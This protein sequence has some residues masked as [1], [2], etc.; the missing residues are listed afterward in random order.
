MSSGVCRVYVCVLSVPPRIYNFASVT[1]QEGEPA[2]LV[3]LS[4]GDPSPD[5]TFQRTG[6]TDV[7]RIGSNVRHCCYSDLPIFTVL[8]SGVD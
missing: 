7:Y 5:L 1:E 8:D 6:H 4:E 2:K 3:C